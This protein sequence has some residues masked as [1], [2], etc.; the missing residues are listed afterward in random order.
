MVLGSSSRHLLHVFIAL[1]HL[2]KVVVGSL[3]GH[4]MLVQKW[5]SLQHHCLGL[6]VA[7]VV[8]NMSVTGVLMQQRHTHHLFS[9]FS[10]SSSNSTSSPITRGISRGSTETCRLSYHGKFLCRLFKASSRP[11]CDDKFEFLN[12]EFTFRTKF[13]S[14]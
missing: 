13:W 4:S 9:I 8:M 1:D 14:F 7:V 2:G 12:L 6:S 3:G 5:N 11:A 10:W